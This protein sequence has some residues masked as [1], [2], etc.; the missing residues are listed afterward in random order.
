M[1]ALAAPGGPR[2]S[3]EARHCRASEAQRIFAD[4][5][6]RVA[7]KALGHL[8]KTP[9]SGPERGSICL[10]PLSSFLLRFCLAF[11]ADFVSIS[12]C[13]LTSPSPIFSPRRLVSCC[14]RSFGLLFCQFR[15]AS[16]DG[17]K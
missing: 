17:Q 13:F 15:Q 1:G 9:A 11:V 7:C 10:E 3:A 12:S 16:V 2:S 5:R 8:S 14:L 4:P 6:E